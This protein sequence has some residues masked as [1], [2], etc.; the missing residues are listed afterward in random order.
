MLFLGAGGIFPADSNGH[1]YALVAFDRCSIA[2]WRFPGAYS[3]TWCPL[4][5]ANTSHSVPLASQRCHLCFPLG[6]SQHQLW[7][8]RVPGLLQVAAPLQQSRWLR[9]AP[10]SGDEEL[11]AVDE[12]TS[13]SLFLQPWG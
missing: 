8:P 5:G 3:G 11:L 10:G 1:L 2:A 13:S 4:S 12:T 7:E 6:M 9:D